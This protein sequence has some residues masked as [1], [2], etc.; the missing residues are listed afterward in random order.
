MGQRGNG[1]GLLL[2]RYRR[3]RLNR[4]PVAE[5]GVLARAPGGFVDCDGG[6]AHARQRIVLPKTGRMCRSANQRT[7]G[8][9]RRSGC[10]PWRVPEVILSAL[11][12]AD[13]GPGAWRGSFRPKLKPLWCQ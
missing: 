4:S 11:T 7:F 6:S 10:V 9:R 3:R 1:K 8:A 13:A 12:R 2:P 5:T